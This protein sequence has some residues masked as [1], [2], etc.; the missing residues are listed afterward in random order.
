MHGRLRLPSIIRCILVFFLLISAVTKGTAIIQIY[1]RRSNILITSTQNK[2]YH[3]AGTCA[4]TQDLQRYR[5]AVL[6]P[7]QAMCWQWPFT[8]PLPGSARAGARAAWGGGVRGGHPFDNIAGPWCVH[9]SASWH[10][11]T[12]LTRT[13]ITLYGGSSSYV[14][15]DGLASSLSNTSGTCGRRLMLPGTG[16]LASVSGSAGSPGWLL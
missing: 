5:D 12:G 7:S 14:P 16:K 2:T 3:E 6:R 11:L 4:N 13:G 9:P 15:G 1:I 10:D 8:D